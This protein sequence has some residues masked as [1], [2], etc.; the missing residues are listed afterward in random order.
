MLRIAGESK[1]PGGNQAC[2]LTL[3][4]SPVFA[5][6]VPASSRAE[7]AFQREDHTYSP[8]SDGLLQR[9]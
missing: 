8:P 3:I 2:L 4:S 6:E 9:D 1:F 7:G 5:G